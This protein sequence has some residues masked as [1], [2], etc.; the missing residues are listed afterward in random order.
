ML[1]DRSLGGNY[2]LEYNL[3]FPPVCFTGGIH[4]SPPECGNAQKC[5]AFLALENQM[6]F[7]ESGSEKA[8]PSPKG[9]HATSVFTGGGRLSIDLMIKSMHRT[10]KI[11]L[12]ATLTVLWIILTIYLLGALFDPS[13]MLTLGI[14]FWLVAIISGLLFIIMVR[15]LVLVWTD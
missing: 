3:I 10:H 11:I 14:T 12:T 2:R 13:S 15:I 8:G 1:N 9:E 7:D 4:H 6:I 5:N